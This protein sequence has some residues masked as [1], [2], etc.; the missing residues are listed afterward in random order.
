MD[1]VNRAIQGTNDLE[2]MMSDVLDAVLSIFNC[3]RAWL[4]YPC[5]PEAASWKVSM[6]HTRPEFLGAFALRLDF[7][8]DPD[9]AKMFQAVRAA[10]GP[11]Q[12][13]PG[14]AHPLP[15]EAAKRFRI[16]SIIATV[17]YP[18]GEKSY[19][20]G[21]HQC[22]CPRAWTLWEERLSR[23]LADGWKTR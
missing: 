15:P 6:E 9:I 19:L 16:Q 20:F 22:S 12:F 17:L 23:R 8:V 13:G 1:R 21:L 18:K 4:V 7:P 3:D 2:Q 10:S 14:S 11:V 5:E